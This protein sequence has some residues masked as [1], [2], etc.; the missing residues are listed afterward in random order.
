MSA[1]FLGGRLEA[2]ARSGRGGGEGFVWNHP[3][4]SIFQKTFQELCF[5]I[6]HIN[7]VLEIPHL[8]KACI[9]PCLEIIILFKRS[10]C[11][12]ANY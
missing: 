4:A 8:L 3:A 9:I 7:D 12:S 10:F 11:P 5:K 1:L 6:K 2:W